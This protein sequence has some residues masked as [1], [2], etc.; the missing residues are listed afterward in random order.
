MEVIA[1]S[2]HFKIGLFNEEPC[3]VLGNDRGRDIE[4]FGLNRLE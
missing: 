3:A 1:F 2:I 4:R